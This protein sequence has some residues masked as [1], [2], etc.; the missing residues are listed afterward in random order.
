MRFT[1]QQ[2]MALKFND[3]RINIVP[4]NLMIMQSF[5]DNFTE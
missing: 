4:K 3:K 1:D 5:K 2:I